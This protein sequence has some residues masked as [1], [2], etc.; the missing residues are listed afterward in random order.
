[1]LG[2]DHDSLGA[3]LESANDPNPWRSVMKSFRRLSTVSL[4]FALWLSTA[5]FTQ[6]SLVISSG[7]GTTHVNNLVAN[8]SFETGAPADGLANALNFADPLAKNY[9]AIPSWVGSGPNS[10][11]AWGNDA[12]SPYRLLFSDLL[13]DG[14]AAVALKTSTGTTVNM[15]PAPPQPNGRVLFP[16]TPTFSIVAGAPV[17]LS[18]ASI[19]TNAFPAPSYNLSFWVSGEENST[20]QGNIGLGL[21]GMQLTNVLPGDPIQWLVVPNGL[22]PPFGQSWL[23]EFTFTPLNPLAPVDISFIN[24]GGLDLSAWGGTP[25][26]TQ[27]ILDDVIINPVPEPASLALLLSGLA[28]IVLWRR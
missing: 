20:N 10:V 2:R 26:G 6:A 28:I 1:M 9:G 14:A 22:I 25:F 7:L 24:P 27:P 18:Q 16:G 8:G 13:P 5:S 3:S 4:S 23:Y 19:P 15:P 17:V 21:I 12:G 11:A